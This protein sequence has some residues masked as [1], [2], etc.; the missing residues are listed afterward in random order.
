MPRHSLKLL[1]LLVAITV[2]PANAGHRAAGSK[3]SSCPYERA[4]LA[5]QA[6][7]MPVARPAPT[8]KAP[9]TITLIDRVPS[10]SV[11]GLGHGSG[12]VSP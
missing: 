11:L 1:A 4:R 6:A 7:A 5:A 2:A 3:D 9:T 8:P 12:F 10:E